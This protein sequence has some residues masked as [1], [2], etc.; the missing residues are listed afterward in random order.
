MVARSLPA[1]RQVHLIQAVLGEEGVPVVVGDAGRTH[2]S[3]AEVSPEFHASSKKGR[4]G[5][6]R[7]AFQ[8]ELGI[9]LRPSSLG[10]RSVL[11]PPRFPLTAVFQPASTLVPQ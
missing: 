11:P 10:A 6:R 4:N 9:G 2:R 3:L 1:G 8:I 5:G 7:S